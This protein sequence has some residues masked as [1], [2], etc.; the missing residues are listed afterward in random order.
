LVSLEHGCSRRRRTHIAAA[1]PSCAFAG[2]LTCGM[3]VQLL[4]VTKLAAR[5]TLLWLHYGVSP[6]LIVWSVAAAATCWRAASIAR[7]LH[8]M[9]GAVQGRLLAVMAPAAV[10]GALIPLQSVFAGNL[11]LVP[12]VAWGLCALVIAGW[13]AVYFTGFTII[14]HRE[15][16]LA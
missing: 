15:C 16:R 2:V 10:L 3:Q 9:S 7:E 12:L 8:D 5:D 1:E 11:S 14:L 13:C 6:L 4:V